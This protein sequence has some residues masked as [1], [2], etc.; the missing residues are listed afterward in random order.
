MN[1]D[2]Y[3]YGKKIGDERSGFALVIGAN[4]GTIKTG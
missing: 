3:P 2:K 1:K 4:T